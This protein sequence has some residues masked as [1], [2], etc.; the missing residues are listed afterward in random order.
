[1]AD[2]YSNMVDLE[3]LES[4]V[5]KEI[6][7]LLRKSKENTFNLA[8]APRYPACVHGIIRPNIW[9]YP[10]DSVSQ[11]EAASGTPLGARIKIHARPLG[12]RW[13]WPKVN[14]FE[15][16]YA[17]GQKGGIKQTSIL[18]R[19]LQLPRFYGDENADK[20]TLGEV[21]WVNWGNKPSNNIGEW[22]D[23]IYLGPIG[24]KNKV[25]CP[26]LTGLHRKENLQAKF[27]QA[28]PGQAQISS[29]VDDK[30]AYNNPPPGYPNIP[31]KGFLEVSG[32]VHLIKEIYVD[33]ELDYP[34]IQNYEVI[35]GSKII[36]EATDEMKQINFI[37]HRPQNKAFFLPDD[38]AIKQ[39]KK[40][41]LFIIRE[42]GKSC[43]ETHKE[44]YHNPTM[45]YNIAMNS[46]LDGDHAGLE[47]KSITSKDRLCT[48]RVNVPFGIVIDEKDIFSAN[49]V[50][51][52]ISSPFDGKRFFGLS[53]SLKS[54]NKS[55]LTNI[56]SSLN[57]WITEKKLPDG[58]DPFILGPWGLP[59][60]RTGL[61]ADHNSPVSSLTDSHFWS[62]RLTWSPTGH[63]FLPTLDQAAALYD[64]ITSVVETPPKSAY[65][66][67]FTQSMRYLHVLAWN[68][69]AVG[70]GHPLYPISHFIDTQG[71]YTEETP[72][73]PWGQVGPLLTEKKNKPVDLWENGL[74][75]KGESAIF[76]VV[77]YSRWG[78]D[79]GP[80]LEYYILGRK[81]GLGHM[82]SWYVSLAVSAETIPRLHK[83]KGL[84]PTI[85]PAF[86][87][88]ALNKYLEIGQW[89]WFRALRHLKP[90]EAALPEEPPEPPGIPPPPTPDKDEW[91]IVDPR[92]EF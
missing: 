82:E 2:F 66:W 37:Q 53:P 42:T 56:K 32:L 67:G 74:K 36:K 83:G 22:T 38:L 49:S 34:N 63:Y 7:G 88:I 21:V 41:K 33:K 35:P 73:F 4:N 69:P 65:S 86:G 14:G 72:A 90:P 55:D 47:K 12:K 70:G 84:G 91:Y 19:V 45:H 71:Y 85:I 30:Y 68:F 10:T 54:V 46:V 43:I 62:G 29:P 20:C 52:M 6:I 75:H 87:D 17:D 81:L 79:S 64:L 51:C 76:G 3:G 44:I 48:I 31:T 78:M 50:G 18:D 9:N 80:F 24:I 26:D 92:C 28:N 60:L 59:G 15:Y 8:S 77:S 39:R 57:Q 1:M 16:I 13:P 58:S 23:P 40:T 61:Q 27:N 89:M 5:I 11:T 25:M